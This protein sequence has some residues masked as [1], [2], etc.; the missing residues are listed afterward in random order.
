MTQIQKKTIADIDLQKIGGDH[1]N[2]MIVSVFTAL[3]YEMLSGDKLELAMC[4]A[5]KVA[6]QNGVP[7]EVAREFVRKI[8]IVMEAGRRRNPISGMF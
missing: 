5:I 2:A 8:H 6:M 1:T 3:S 7:E 4:G